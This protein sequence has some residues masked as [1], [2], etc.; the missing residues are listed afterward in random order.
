MAHLRIQVDFDWTLSHEHLSADELMSNHN[1]FYKQKQ[2]KTFLDSLL[3]FFAELSQS[4][5]LQIH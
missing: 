4:A 5:E 1:H 3:K 2:G